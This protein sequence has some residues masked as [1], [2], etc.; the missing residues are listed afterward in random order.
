MWEQGAAIM[1]DRW[2]CRKGFGREDMTSELGAF[3]AMADEDR[4]QLGCSQKGP[5]AWKRK[6]KSAY[7]L[8]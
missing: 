1:R 6:C 3:Q 2:A 5:G 7:L 8:R 4:E